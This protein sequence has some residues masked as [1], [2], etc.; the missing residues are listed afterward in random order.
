MMP[1]MTSKVLKEIIER[2]EQWPETRQEDAARVLLDMEEQ[3]ASPCSLTDEQAAEVQRRRADLNR[4]FLTL[5]KV[6]E[7]FDHRRS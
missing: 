5:E 7:R 6:R 3:D 2:V 4:K 1:T